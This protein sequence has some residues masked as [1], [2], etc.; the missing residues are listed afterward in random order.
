MNV[1][2]AEETGILGLV[3]SLDGVREPGKLS[4]LR[5]QKRAGGQIEVEVIEGIPDLGEIIVGSH[6]NNHGEEDDVSRYQPSKINTFRVVEEL[7]QDGRFVVTACDV[8]L[9]WD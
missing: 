3:P 4:T 5:A 8:Q 6:I 7:T 1:A 2:H 9:S